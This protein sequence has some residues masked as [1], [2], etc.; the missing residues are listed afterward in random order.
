MTRKE[1]EDHVTTWNELVDFGIT[2]DIE[3]CDGDEVIFPG[4]LNSYIVDN[5][6]EWVDD[7]GW[8]R[9]VNRLYNDIPD[10]V[11]YYDVY[12]CNGCL[13]VGSCDGDANFLEA[14]GAAGDLAE[15]AGIIEEE[16]TA[17]DEEGVDGAK[18]EDTTEEFSLSRDA[19]T[20]LI[21]CDGESVNIFYQQ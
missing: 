21:D 13:I 6:S 20:I 3:F 5:I 11:D 12:I 4:D 1:F 9:V 17:P 16:A 10:T 15:G 19:K 8:R 7:T 2:N 18:E 14:R